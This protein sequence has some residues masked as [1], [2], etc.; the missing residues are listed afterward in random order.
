MP[1]KLEDYAT[2]YQ[3]VRFERRGGILQ[4]TLHTDG[5]SLR[6]ILCRIKTARGVVF[7]ERS[8]LK[9]PIAESSFRPELLP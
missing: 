3:C 5:G 4:M 9:T 6:C 2:K 8:E 7:N 1:T